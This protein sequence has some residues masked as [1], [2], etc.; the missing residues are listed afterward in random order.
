MKGW[1]AGRGTGKVK[2]IATML[3]EQRLRRSR[4]ALNQASINAS[5]TTAA[6]AKES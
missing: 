2:R 3:H 5:E 6:V 4:D 1:H